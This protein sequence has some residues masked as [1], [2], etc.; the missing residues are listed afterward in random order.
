[1]NELDKIA[2]GKA[3]EESKVNI[4]NHYNEYV[5]TNKESNLYNSNEEIIGVIGN[6]VSLSLEDTLINKD[7]KYFKVKDFEDTYIEY[8]DVEKIGSLIT[9][10]DRYKNYIVFNDV[11]MTNGENTNIELIIK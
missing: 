9:Y 11:T 8:N 10:D 7:T 3:I 2:M 6:N 1:M 4:S 5:I